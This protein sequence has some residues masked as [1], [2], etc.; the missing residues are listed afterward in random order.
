MSIFPQGE[1]WNSDFFIESD[2]HYLAKFT[3]GDLSSILLAGVL[4]DNDVEPLPQKSDLRIHSSQYE[5]EHGIDSS[6]RNPRL[7]IGIK[8][9]F[10][11]TDNFVEIV[12]D[13]SIRRDIKIK[14]MRVSPLRLLGGCELLGVLAYDGKS[15]HPLWLEKP[16][17]YKSK[18]PFLAALFKTP[19]GKLFEIGTGDDLCRWM[20]AKGTGSAVSSF[21]IEKEGEEWIV[22]RE[23]LFFQGDEILKR[24]DIRLSWYIVFSNGN[25]QHGLLEGA[26]SNHVFSFKDKSC[27]D[28]AKISWKKR[29][30]EIPC[31]H[32][33]WSRNM[34]KNFI[35]GL[36]GKKKSEEIFLTDI[37][38]P[39]CDL[40]SH[41]GRSDVKKRPHWNILEI[42]K[43]RKWAN[44]QLAT[45]GA[46]IS[47]LPVPNSATS[48]LLGFQ[49][50]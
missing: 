2:S 31:M 7:D 9:R 19:D 27:P 46:R 23:I 40:S 39:L 32:A 28:N 12:N 29:V 15:N 24:R 14:S 43:L 42:N 45:S 18:I 38:L 37:E 33:D 8:R 3:V 20:L 50:K 26:D 13:I 49:Q 36:Q 4:V 48:K 41:L 1:F 16:S 21:V 35:R 22:E 34:L 5:G 25:K 17:E 6:S 10:E 44:R 30:E 47:L 11:F